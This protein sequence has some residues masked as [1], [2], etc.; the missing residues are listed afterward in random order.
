[1]SSDYASDAPTTDDEP[2]QGELILIA[3]DEPD[4]RELATLVLERAGYRT[5]AFSDGVSALEAA[6]NEEPALCLLDVM[7]PRMNGFEVLSAI[8]S[9]ERTNSIKTIICTATIQDERDVRDGGPGADAYIRKPFSTAEL[10]GT[11]ET[12]LG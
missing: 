3:E 4:I 7:M 6:R 5:I 12:L 2:R 11:V 10:Q 1:M 9:D 8:K